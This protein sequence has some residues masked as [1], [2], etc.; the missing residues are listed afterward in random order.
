MLLKAIYK[1]FAN[2]TYRQIDGYQHQLLGFALKIQIEM[3]A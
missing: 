3:L 1:M 2:F